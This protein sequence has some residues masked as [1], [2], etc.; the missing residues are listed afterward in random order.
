MRSLLPIPIRQ[1][2]RFYPPNDL[3]TDFH[4]PACRWHFGCRTERGQGCIF[5]KDAD[6]EIESDPARIDPARRSAAQDTEIAFKFRR[7]PMCCLRA[8]AAKFAWETL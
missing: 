6:H 2:A 4:V 3:S 7:I 1:A 8:R 5:G